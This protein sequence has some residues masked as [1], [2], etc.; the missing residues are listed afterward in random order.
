[1]KKFKAWIADIDGTPATMICNE[2]I[3]RAEAREEII[4]RFPKA[5]ERRVKPLRKDKL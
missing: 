2:P 1:V 4:A 3:T 5:V